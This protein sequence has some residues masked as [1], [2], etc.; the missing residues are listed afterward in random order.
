MLTVRPG[1]QRGRP[2]SFCDE[3]RPGRPHHRTVREDRRRDRRDPM[4]GQATAVERRRAD[5]PGRCAGPAGLRL[6]GPLAS[7]R[8]RQPDLDVPVSDQAAG[9]QQAAAGRVAAG[10]EGDTPPRDGYGLLVRQ[11]L[12]RRLHAGAVRHVEADGEAV[13]PGL[14]GRVRV[15]RIPLPVLLGPASVPGL[16]PDRHADGPWRTR[17]ST[18]GR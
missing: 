8:S 17:R 9:I 5:L 15:L 11:P 2:R 14:L 18:S 4:P 12:D 6:R 13:E 16:H 10:E 7:V 3:R 1:M